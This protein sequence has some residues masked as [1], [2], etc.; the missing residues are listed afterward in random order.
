[1]K[2]RNKIYRLMLNLDDVNAQ[3]FILPYH[4]HAVTLE[5]TLSYAQNAWHGREVQLASALN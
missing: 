5:E 1:M 3:V 2:L 4:A